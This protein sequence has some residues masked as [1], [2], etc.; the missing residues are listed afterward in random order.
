MS[1]YWSFLISIVLFEQVHQASTFCFTQCR[2]DQDCHGSCRDSSHIPVCDW[3]TF[4]FDRELCCVCKAATC[5][6]D[7]DCSGH[8]C[9]SGYVSKCN[10]QHNC[11]CERK[12]T[13]TFDI[14]CSNHCASGYTPT[15]SNSQCHCQRVVTCSSDADCSGQSC[16]SGFVSKCNSKNQC[17]CLLKSTCSVDTDCSNHCISGY[18]AT[19]S[20]GHCQCHAH[21]ESTQMTRCSFNSDCANYHCSSGRSSYCRTTFLDGHCDCLECRLDTDC[22]QQYQ[23][24]YSKNAKARFKIESDKNLRYNRASAHCSRN[25]DC[26]NLQCSSGHTPVCSLS[27]HSCHCQTTCNTHHDCSHMTCRHGYYLV[28]SAAQNNTKT[29]VCK[30]TCS[31]QDECTNYACSSQY[32]SYC[33][34]GH[35]HCAHRCSSDSYCSHYGH[36]AHSSRQRCST[37]LGTICVCEECVHDSE[38]SNFH[39]QPYHSPICKNNSCSCKADPV[40]GIWSQW[41][42]WTTC[43][44]TCGHGRQTRERSCTNPAPARGGLP[45]SGNSSEERNCSQISSCRIDGGWS[46]WVA[47]SIC[48]VSCGGGTHTRARM[49]S[50]PVPSN[51]GSYCVGDVYQTQTCATAACGGLACPTCDHNLVCAFNNTCDSSETCMIRSYL[52]TRFTVHCSKKEDCAFEQSNLNGEIYCCDDHS[53]IQRYLG[54]D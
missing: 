5:S 20:N 14:N 40:D 41:E 36:C 7:T 28:C 23:Y 15:C 48:S 6:S 30:S 9:N 8:S 26:A 24:G 38:C 47:W 32:K 27:T 19:C 51:G 44:V 31:M 21:K 18:T 53:C 25:S 17:Q 52:K 10:S 33:Q 42:S 29:C 43:S 34:S 2:T 39:C 46:D 37:Y 13:C 45:C 49:C 3:V 50:N 35:C 11:H 1:R 54:I 22:S 12:P 4:I 16:N